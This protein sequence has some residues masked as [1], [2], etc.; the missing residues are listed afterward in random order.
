MWGVHNA[1]WGCLLKLCVCVCVCVCVYLGLS[2]ESG[3]QVS[4][5]TSSKSLI[6]AQPNI[7]NFCFLECNL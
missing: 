5:L 3:A 2:T 7:E 1:D 6:Y 4:S